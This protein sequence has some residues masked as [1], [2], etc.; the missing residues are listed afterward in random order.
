MPIDMFRRDSNPVLE[1]SNRRSM[2]VPLIAAA[3]GYVAGAVVHNSLPPPN[4]PLAF[5][6]PV[7][8]AQA[9][10]DAALPL[11]ANL[12][13]LPSADELRRSDAGI[14]DPRE[15]DLPK[16]ISTACLFMD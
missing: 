10:S 3:I 4:D 16:G 2:F 9:N 12:F 6:Q 7:Q 5:A 11:A 15:C 8:A 13:T 14:E 1:G